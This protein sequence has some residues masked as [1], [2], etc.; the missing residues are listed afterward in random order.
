MELFGSLPVY[1]QMIL[2]SPMT[3]D[4]WDKIKDSDTVPAYLNNIN[5]D[6]DDAQRLRGH[7]P[8]DSHVSEQ[9]LA[10]DVIANDEEDNEI[11]LD[12]SSGFVDKLAYLHNTQNLT[13]DMN[14]KK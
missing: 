13:P 3:P 6:F 12:L 2:G 8:D 9:D 10:A 1:I 7:L 4:I 11:F 14:L 5:I